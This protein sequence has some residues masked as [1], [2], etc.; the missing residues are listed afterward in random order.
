MAKAYWV[1]AYHEI[2]DEDKLAAHST[3]YECLVTLS[4]LLAPIVPFISESMYR[5]LAA[6]GAGGC[7]SVHL[8]SYPVSGM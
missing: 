5:N 2:H 7:E 8:E 6:N 3:L 1:A 4:R